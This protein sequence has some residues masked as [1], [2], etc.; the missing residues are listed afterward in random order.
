MWAPGRKGMQLNLFILESLFF[1]L[2]GRAAVGTMV[3]GKTTRRRFFLI[4]H[5]DT[6]ARSFFLRASV[7]PW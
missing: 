6:E 5:G 2:K 7:S 4:H 3:L 1:I